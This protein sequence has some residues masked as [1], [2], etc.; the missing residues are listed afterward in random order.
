MMTRVATVIDE[1]INGVHELLGLLMQ[2]LRTATPGEALVVLLRRV[3]SEGWRD[4]GSLGGI[5]YSVHGAGCR[6]SMPD[7]RVF[8]L[9]LDAASQT[10]IWDAWRVREFAQEPNQVVDVEA[11]EELLRIYAARGDLRETRP[12]WF[13]I[14][15]ADTGAAAHGRS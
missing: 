1:F 10:V 2:E 13:S 12:S 5:E 6:F 9:D 7:G 14:P 3:R 11:V 4:H 8:D 15:A